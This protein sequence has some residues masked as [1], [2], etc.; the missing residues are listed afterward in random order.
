MEGMLKRI[1]YSKLFPAVENLGAFSYR[2]LGFRMARFIV[3]GI[4]VVTSITKNALQGKEDSSK[5]CAM[6]IL[7]VQNIFNMVFRK[8]VVP[9]RR[10]KC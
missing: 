2:Q 5:Y 10:G 1:I 9:R 8:A 4:K 3:D 6:M 7:D